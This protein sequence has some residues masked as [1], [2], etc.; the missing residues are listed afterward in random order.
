MLQPCRWKQNLPRQE[1]VALLSLFELMAT[2]FDLATA[3]GVL[4]N[5]KGLGNHDAHRGG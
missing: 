1:L 3:L 5:I 4:P 2:T